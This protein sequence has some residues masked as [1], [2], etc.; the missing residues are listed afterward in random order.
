MRYDTFNFKVNGY[1]DGGKESDM[2]VLLNTLGVA[3]SHFMI[4][5][6][7]QIGIGKK[8]R[9]WK[10][11][12]ATILMM[13]IFFSG[14]IL[15]FFVPLETTKISFMGIGV[16]FL[17]ILMTFV[18]CAVAN[19][20]WKNG[21]YNRLTISFLLGY[22]LYYFIDFVISYL[23]FHIFVDLPFWLAMSIPAIFTGFIQG[24]INYL[25]KKSDFK[26]WIQKIVQDRFITIMTIG[27]LIFNC[28]VI[29]YCVNIGLEVLSPEMPQVR[30]D[31][32]AYINTVILYLFLDLM[33][34]I[35]VISICMWIYFHKQKVLNQQ[36]RLLE[37]QLYIQKLEK[38]QKKLRGIQHDYKNILSSIYL[39]AELGDLESIQEFMQQS[40]ELFEVE[41]DNSMKVTQQLANIKLLEIKSLLLVKVMEM[42]KHDLHFN[43]EIPNEIT[44]LDMNILEFNRCLGILIDNAMEAVQNQIEHQL[45]ILLVNEKEQFTVVVKN[46]YKDLPSLSEIWND[47][48]STK[49]KQRGTGL[50]NYNSIISKYSNIFKE[51]K[52]EEHNFLQS[53]SILHNG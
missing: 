5:E 33:L 32:V 28:L 27:M 46:T 24:F 34:T 26:Y 10:N 21:N 13:V 47:G 49:G 37:Q 4:N 38:F 12:V 31:Q 9:M 6:M 14:G 53:F 44:R 2:M 16:G 25:L 52:V 43:V 23:S 18:I 40:V 50:A 7:V 15:L 48:Y 35:A 42:E 19:T 11:I 36:T 8:Q 51:T 17:A 20:I 41:T 22:W 29:S 1:I 30:A 45:D 39:Q 3:L